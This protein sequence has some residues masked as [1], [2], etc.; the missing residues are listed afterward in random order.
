MLSRF[1]S[2][3]SLRRGLAS[4]PRRYLYDVPIKKKPLREVDV[5]DSDVFQRKER[6]DESIW[7][8]QHEKDIR[9]EEKM[10]AMR[11]AKKAQSGECAPINKESKKSNDPFP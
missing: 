4:I 11:A 5:P 1:G 2:S 7:I 9:E 8:A 6:A 10:K 3:L